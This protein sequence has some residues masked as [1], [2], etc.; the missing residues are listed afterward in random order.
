[1]DQ[2]IAE[3]RQATGFDLRYNDNIKPSDAARAAKCRDC[4]PCWPAVMSRI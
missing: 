1:M 2:Y 3:H 4:R